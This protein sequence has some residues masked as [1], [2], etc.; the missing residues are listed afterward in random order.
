[1]VD[2]VS[3]ITTNLRIERITPVPFGYSINPQIRCQ[4]LDPT[5]KLCKTQ[6]KPLVNTGKIWYNKF[7]KPDRDAGLSQ[8]DAGL[9]HRGA[10]LPHGGADLSHRDG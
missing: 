5:P 6:H 2:W 7:V 1:M 9:P 10:D 3:K 4:I 8:W